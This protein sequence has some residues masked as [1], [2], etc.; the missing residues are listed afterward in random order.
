MLGD[1]TTCL[2][3][4]ISCL[5]SICVSWGRVSANPGVWIRNIFMQVFDG[6]FQFQGWRLCGRTASVFEKF[7]LYISTCFFG[8]GGGGVDWNRP[9]CLCLSLHT[10]S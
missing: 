7:S 10:V 9:A 3:Y 6:V 2:R 8:W 4:L 1:Q 5:I